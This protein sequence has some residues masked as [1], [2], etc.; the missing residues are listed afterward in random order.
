MSGGSWSG[1]DPR[2]QL[3]RAAR[4][5]SNFI[6][7]L[8]GG[9]PDESAPQ[10]PNTA[11]EQNPV[12]KVNLNPSLPGFPQISGLRTF[13]AEADPPSWLYI[14]DKAPTLSTVRAIAPMHLTDGLF[15]VDDHLV[16][17]AK[18]R[19]GNMREVPAATS[20]HPLAK[21][22]RQLLM[23]YASKK[24]SRRR[25]PIARWVWSSKRHSR[26]KRGGKKK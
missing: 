23:F 4:G 11:T 15:V 13:I 14:M 24:E 25:K 8:A 26:G 5:V 16:G 12:E 3:T 21:Y 22:G 7:E 9:Q 18:T 20:D 17:Y 19:K 6:T 1:Y 2:P 10:N